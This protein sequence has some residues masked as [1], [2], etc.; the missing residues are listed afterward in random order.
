VLLGQASELARAGV[1][2]RTHRALAGRGTDLAGT[3]LRGQDL[4]GANLRG[5]MLI[6]ADLR[7]AD[8]RLADLAGADLRG[9]NLGGADLRGSLFLTPSQLESAN[10]DHATT[11]SPSSERPAH[12][13]PISPAARESRP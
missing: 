9:A 11:L 10:G 12:W 13:V 3:D 7:R 2:P 4:R 8:L 5:A 6:R 1:G